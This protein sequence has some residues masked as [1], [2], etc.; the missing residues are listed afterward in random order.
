MPLLQ[1]YHL[2]PHSI[3]LPLK[4]LELFPMPSPQLPQRPIY[5]SRRILQ[6][7]E[8]IDKVSA[9]LRR[10]TESVDALEYL[11]GGGVGV[12]YGVGMTISE[13]GYDAGS[14][15]VAESKRIL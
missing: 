1:T 12:G 13:R 3:Q 9:W 7:R 4:Q 11:L 5:P 6:H 10:F 14:K 2:L 8:C 15:P